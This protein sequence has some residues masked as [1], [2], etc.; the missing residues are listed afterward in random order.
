[1]AAGYSQRSLADKLGLAPGRRVFFSALPRDVARE[2]GPLA[3]GS[4]SLRGT[5][6]YLHAFVT[7][8]AELEDVVVRF[9]AVLEPDGM[10]W[11]SWPKKSSGVATDVTEGVIRAVA[12]PRGLVDIKVCAVSDVWSG[13]KL[14]VPVKDRPKRA[15]TRATQRSAPAPSSSTKRASTRRPAAAPAAKQ[16]RRRTR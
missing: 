8:R 10:L 3:Q 6:D 1:M 14:V 4:A 12:L 16:D 9:K 5:F 2:L 13:L 15:S 11:I 7:T